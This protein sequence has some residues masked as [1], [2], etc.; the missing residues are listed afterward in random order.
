MDLWAAALVLGGY[1]LGSI[2]FGLLVTRLLGGPDPRGGGSGNIGATN[3]TRLAGKTAG[4]ATLFLDAAKGTLPTALA[5]HY[6]APAP[7]AAVG[8]A[9]FLGHV[10]PLYL[11]FKGGKGVATALGVLAAV[12]P[13]GLLATMAVLVLAAWWSGHVSVGSLAGCLSA[14]AWLWLLGQ[15]APLV[16]MALVMAALVVWRHKDNIARLRQGSEHGL[17]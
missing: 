2:P 13:L 5:L 9:A 6:L 16:V 1:L 3:V 14:P 10:F 15:P 8:L 7:A 12:T 11:G 17:R 4:V